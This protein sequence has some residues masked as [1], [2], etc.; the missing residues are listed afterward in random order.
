MKLT[1]HFILPV[2]LLFALAPMAGH[3]QDAYLSGL[4]LPRF[5]KANVNY[6]I[7]VK[8][9]NAGS[10]PVPSF[11]VRWKV[12]GGAWNNGNTITVTAPGLQTGYYMNV[13]HP[14][15]LN[16]AQGSH[17]LTVEIVSSPDQVATN[18]QIVS[19]FTA[20]NS[21]VDKVVLYEGRTETWCQY[22]PAANV[23]T[24]NLAENPLFAVA[25]FHTS[26]GL[27]TSETT[28][29]YNTYYHPLFTPAG[30]LDMG[31][32]GG[33]TV[34][35][36]AGAWQDEMAARANGV[37]PV[38]VSLS[39]SLNS[40]T[41]VLSVTVT[42]NFTFAFTGPFK[43]NA[44]LLEDAVA[45]PQTNAPANYQHNKV[46]RALLGGVSGTSGVIPNTPV[47]NTPYSKTYTYTV[48]A[49]YKLGDLK[50]I[51]VVEHAQSVTSRYCVNAA[52]SG[53]GAVGIQELGRADQLLNMYPNPFTNT[54]HLSLDGIAGAAELELVAADGRVVVQHPLM[55]GEMESTTLQL[56]ADLPPGTYIATVR[57]KELIARKAVIKVD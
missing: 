36:N 52:K 57:T 27:A 1:T 9:M 6:P 22:C 20:L 54:L 51:G 32:Y 56:P 18:N 39:S 16:V 50:L 41:R 10:A 40:T 12:D 25:K 37:S 30:V 8:A 48:P 24:N 14:V 3:A 19:E 45:G 15:Q 23:V 26:D 35:S 11:S 13:T 34:N 33:Y 55:L 53:V 38:S 5:I 42:A 44:Y 29:Y 47:V 49:G 2:A 7:L 4:N 31:E 21:Y 46:V 43:L 28:D 17:T